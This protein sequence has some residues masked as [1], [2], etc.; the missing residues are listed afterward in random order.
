MPNP[1]HTDPW[2]RWHINVPSSLAL[3]VETRLLDPVSGTTAYGARAK[4]VEQLL[5]EWLARSTEPK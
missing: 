3:Q 4:L 5:R 2:I 1:K